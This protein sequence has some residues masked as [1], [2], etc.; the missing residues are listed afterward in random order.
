MGEPKVFSKLLEAS[1]DI[2]KEGIRTGFKKLG[3]KNG[4]CLM[5][6]SSLSRFGYVEGGANTVIDALLEVVGKEGTIGM[7]TFCKFK[8]PL[9]KGKHKPETT[10]T[11][12]GK[13]PETFKK[14]E[15]VIRN[16]HPLYS[17]SYKGPKAKILIRGQDKY[18]FPYGRNHVFYKLMVVDAFI[19]LLGVSHRANSIIHMA[20]ELVNVPYLEAKKSVS[21][22]L[23]S[24][25]Y[26]LSSEEQKECREK[27]WS[28]PKRDFNKV[29]GLLG[30]REIVKT[31]V[32]GNAIVSLMPAR[33]FVNLIVRGLK[34]NP[35][36]LVASDHALNRED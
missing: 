30:V 5:V 20:E 23:V 25:F 24:D 9:I 7:P 4:D 17:L 34:E 33:E 32:I 26:R 27:H 6:H 11:H 21:K 16:L 12:L 15:G 18:I 14:R 29:E 31:E 1:Q 3:L 22:I 10:S 36:A 35:E 19:L 2:E 13:I 8:I 28:G